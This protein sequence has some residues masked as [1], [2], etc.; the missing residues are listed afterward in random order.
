MTVLLINVCGVVKIDIKNNV[1]LPT[2][3]PIK[4]RPRSEKRFQ[5]FFSSSVAARNRDVCILIF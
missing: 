2:T 3:Y 4:L 5:F 1:V